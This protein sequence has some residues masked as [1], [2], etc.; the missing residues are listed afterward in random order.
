MCCLLINF[1]EENFGFE[2][3][4]V[5]NI[6]CLQLL[7]F[8]LLLKC[9]LGISQSCTYTVANIHVLNCTIKHL[10]VC[11]TMLRAAYVYDICLQEGDWCAAG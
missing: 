8:L 11:M 9:V 4:F 5:F 6:Y 7:L 1:V 2:A 10:C 3:H